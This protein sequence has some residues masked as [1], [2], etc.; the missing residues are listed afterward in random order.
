LS[1]LLGQGSA[2]P[3]SSQDEKIQLALKRL[4]DALASV[5][6]RSSMVELGVQVLEDPERQADEFSS[7][8][9]SLSFQ[10]G[11][12]M[13]VLQA[14]LPK[15]TQARSL[16]IYTETLG[17]TTAHGSHVQEAGFGSLIKEIGGT[18]SSL[19][20]DDTSGECRPLG[21][22]DRSRSSL[23]CHH[24]CSPATGPWLSPCTLENYLDRDEYKNDLTKQQRIRIAR[25]LTIP[26]MHFAKVVNSTNQYPRP[27]RVRYYVRD[28]YTNTWLNEIGEPN[29]LNPF[30]TTGFGMQKAARLPGISS[31]LSRQTINPVVELGLLLYQI[32]SGSN[33][34]YGNGDLGVK[35]AKEVALGAMSQVDKLSNGS[36]SELV[37]CCLGWRGDV[38]APVE[39]QDFVTIDRVRQWLLKNEG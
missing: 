36:F 9:S 14:H 38:Y 32:G 23:D 4:H 37:Q 31:G 7:F 11:S 2:W 16:F 22:V 1:T 3:K 12:F 13:F 29:I 6:P 35:N 19:A 27:N 18:V 10:P 24:L 5:N 26:F 15:D 28:G 20:I 30:V 8:E 17:P 33:L 21:Y 34:N 39:D 25:V